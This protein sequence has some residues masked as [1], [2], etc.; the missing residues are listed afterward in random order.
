VQTGISHYFVLNTTLN[1]SGGR[2]LDQRRLFRR[3]A[4]RKDAPHPDRPTL[5]ATKKG[6]NKVKLKV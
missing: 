3:Q 6:I 5:P 2:L 1:F 4:R